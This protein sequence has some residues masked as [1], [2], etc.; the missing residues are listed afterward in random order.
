MKF[1]STVKN[2]IED[3]ATTD[4]KGN[5]QGH[6][7]IPDVTAPR[8]LEAKI[9]LRAG[10]PGGRAVERMLTLPILP[11]SGLIGVK[12]KFDMLGEGAIATFDVI[13]VGADGKRARAQGRHLVALSHQQ[14]L[15]MV[16]SG[17]PLGLRAGQILEAHRRR[18]DR[19]GHRSGGEDLPPVDFG[20]YRLDVASRRP[21][22]APT[23]VSFYAGWWARPRPIRPTFSTSR[24]IRAD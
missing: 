11:K 21:D 14:R 15:S 6:V 18:Q 16:Q 8:P 3:T 23:S 5:A 19:S 2:D 1:S 9:M 20:E 7:P 4:A 13:A 24:S 10:E 12:K 22:D 17:R